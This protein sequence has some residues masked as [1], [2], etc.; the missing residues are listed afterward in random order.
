[1]TDLEQLLVDR[2]K[3]DPA[4]AGVLLVYLTGRDELPPTFTDRAPAARGE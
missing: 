1:V 4:W 3:V 2:A